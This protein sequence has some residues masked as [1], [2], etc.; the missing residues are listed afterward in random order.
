MAARLVSPVRLPTGR[1]LAQLIRQLW[2]EQEAAMMSALR[3]YGAFAFT[4]FDARRWEQALAERIK[5]ILARYL[6][7]GKEFVER[8]LAAAMADRKRATTKAIVQFPSPLIDPQ[9][10]DNWDIYNPEAVNFINTYSYNFAASTIATTRGKLA[11]AYQK[12]QSDLAQ[13]IEQGEA[14]KTVTASVMRTFRDPQRA[15]T[16]AATEA[17]RAYNYGRGISAKQSGVV[18]GKKW[19]ASSDACPEC[20]KLDGK[21]V[22]LD[23]PFT[24]LPGGGPYARV[25]Y[26]PLHPRCFCDWTEELNDEWNPNE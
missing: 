11:T 16:I 20:L 21:V 10:D 24:I 22:P 8:R 6:I 23:D 17:S 4:Q 3:Q 15:M 12:L 5:P 18:S 1:Q 7:D 9:D 13:G 25:M 14:L 2:K 26:P 19:L